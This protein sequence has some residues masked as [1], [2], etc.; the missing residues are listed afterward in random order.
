MKSI[1]NFLQETTY[2]LKGKGDRFSGTGKKNAPTFAW[3]TIHGKPFPG[4]RPGRAPGTVDREWNGIMV[5]ELLKDEWLLALNNIKE[6][7]M[8]SSCQG[9][10]PKGEW[11]SFVIFR[12]NTKID[13]NKF[14]KA[15][16]DGRYTFCKIEV[17]QGGLP[18]CCVATPLFAKGPN[19]TLW[20]KWWSTLADRI[21][22]AIRKSK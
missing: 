1:E 9:H 18:R 21:K 3:E 4:R 8:R 13:H 14:I 16:S 17:G 19:H 22:V 10:P 12:F 2:W 20:E 5:D 15:I 11:P 6:I 7:E